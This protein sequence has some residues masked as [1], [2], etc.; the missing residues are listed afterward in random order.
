MP[1]T[2]E[3]AERLESRARSLGAPLVVVEMRASKSRHDATIGRSR[4]ELA[5]CV[6]LAAPGPIDSRYRE[7][8]LGDLPADDP[9]SARE[10]V[11]TARLLATRL[12]VPLYPG[13]TSRAAQR[14][15]PEAAQYPDAATPRWL[16][17]Q[18]PSPVRS[19][20]VA[21]SQV[22]WQA[23][24]TKVQEEGERSLGA[25]SGNE[26][27]DRVRKE[28]IS[29]HHPPFR[30]SLACQDLGSPSAE[31]SRDLGSRSAEYHREHRGETIPLRDAM[32]E[33]VYQGRSLVEALRSLEHETPPL[34]PLARMLL[35]EEA[36]LLVLDE[37][38]AVGAFCRGEL[39]GEA[40]DEALGPA[41]LRHKVRW[42]LPLQFREVHARGQ[43]IGPLMHEVY[44][45]TGP[46]GLIQGLREAFGISLRDGKE[47]VGT[48]CGN[49]HHEGLVALLTRAIKD[50]RSA[51]TQD[52][53]SYTVTRGAG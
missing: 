1:T 27:L 14:G 32:R 20:S 19:W 6:M 11:A 13:E 45:D 16:S 12:G 21:W 51:S 5:L 46:L 2:K 8:H 37:L 30:F 17:R 47:L 33:S 38:D 9:P 36:F 10:A 35:V 52:S 31:P 43:S 49:R 39:S 25:T 28:R 24:G 3:T 34:T 50:R 23:D 44:G 29:A 18:G 41:L 15:A 26:A 40:L 4:H 53:R 22:R 7:E 42:S 48:A